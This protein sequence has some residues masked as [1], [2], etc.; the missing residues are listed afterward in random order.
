MLNLIEGQKRDL[1]A[2]SRK[3][4]P[5]HVANVM[6]DR[7][8]NIPTTNDFYYHAHRAAVKNMHWTY[9]YAMGGEYLLDTF[10]QG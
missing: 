4:I 7:M 2:A 8:Y 6:A 9:T 10:V 5:K 1:D 3:N